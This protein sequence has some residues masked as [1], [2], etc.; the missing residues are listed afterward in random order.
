MYNFLKRTFDVLF[1]AIVLLVV[2]PIFLIIAIG[3]KVSS[4]GPVFHVSERVGRNGK[5]FKMYKFRSMHLKDENTVE[6]KYLVNTQRI[7]PFG[8]FLRKSKMDELPQMVSVLCGHMSFVGP[9]PYPK[10]VVERLFTGDNSIITSVRPGLACLD[11]L[12]DYSHG[13]LFVTDTEYY[14][15]YIIP[16]RTELAKMYVEKRSVSLD[17]HC[18]ARTI[19]LIVQIV[20]LGKRHF[21][22]T[23]YEEQAHN[24]LNL[25]W[26]DSKKKVEV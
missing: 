3:I 1:S 6:N 14:K 10:S 7:F 26:V 18:I 12:Y 19:I 11:S 24:N 8:V 16:V 22:L 15:N 13:D 2:S 9:R 20:V 17:A 21:R 4:K 5:I 25:E 23:K